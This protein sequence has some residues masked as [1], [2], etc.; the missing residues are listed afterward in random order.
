MEQRQTIAALVCFCIA[1]CLA[2]SSGVQANQRPSMVYSA[3]SI[4]HPSF[5]PKLIQNTIQEARIGRRAISQGASSS[6]AYFAARTTLPGTLVAEVKEQRSYY[7][8][9]VA[10]LVRIPN[11]SAFRASKLL[12]TVFT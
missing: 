1:S 5:S 7:Q 10:P 11:K 9:N 2:L 3:Q 6:G 4:S 12:L 8:N